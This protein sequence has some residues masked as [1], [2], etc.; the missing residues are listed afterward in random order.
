MSYKSRTSGPKRT[1]AKPARQKEVKFT[2]AKV[3]D[4]RSIKTS[5]RASRKSETIVTDAT[6]VWLEII[7]DLKIQIKKIDAPEDGILFRGQRDSSWDLEPSIMRPKNSKCLKNEANIYLTF[8]TRAGHL[9]NNCKSSWEVLTTMQHHGV[10][11]RLIDWSDSFA[12]AL[13]FAL[14]NQKLSEPADV[15]V[16]ILNGFELSRR[17][18]GKESIYTLGV[19]EFPDYAEHFVEGMSNGKPRNWPYEHPVALEARWSHP[20]MCAQRAVFTSHGKTSK[21]LNQNKACRDVLEQINIPAK[22]V[23]HARYFLRLA[24]IDNFSLFPDLDGLA[25][26]VRYEHSPG[27]E[28]S[29]YDAIKLDM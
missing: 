14:R 17:S 3:S 6:K 22:V 25:E 19:D 16:W 18:T 2:A 10:P 23:P 13:F 5:P 9:L 21:P 29:I 15:K 20:R 24:G 11:T 28:G 1:S 4:S 8:V 27:V 7:E 12:V 26:L